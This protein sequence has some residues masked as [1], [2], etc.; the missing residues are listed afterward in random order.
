MTH[1]I[2]K[3]LSGPASIPDFHPH[4]LFTEARAR[5]FEIAL[6]IFRLNLRQTQFCLYSAATPFFHEQESSP[7]P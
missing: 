2:R 4:A 7:Q 5:F 6:P 3:K 1:D